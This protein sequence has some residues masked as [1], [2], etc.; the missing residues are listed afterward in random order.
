VGRIFEAL[1]A[2]NVLDEAAVLISADHGEMLGELNVYGDHQA[3]DGQTC[4]VPCILKWPGMAARVDR[5]L[6]YQIDVTGMILEMLGGKVPESWDG[7]SKIDRPYLVMSQAAWAV[8]RAVRFE[9]YICIR[10]YFDPHHGW[11]E[12][13]L[14]DV[15]N[16]PHE[17]QD[18]ARERPEVVSRGLTMLE[19]WH[20]EMR[21]EFDPMQTVLNEGGGFYTRGKMER[22]LQRLRETGRGKAAEKVCR[23]S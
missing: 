9:N 13:M 19:E 8:Q 11:P 12:A 14:F 7:Q 3:A 16:D 4:H 21:V 15:A 6:R 1:A 18:L 20:R 2:P 23:I 17:Q 22:Y 5:G 10:T